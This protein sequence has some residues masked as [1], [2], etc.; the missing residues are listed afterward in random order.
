[1]RRARAVAY[2]TT[3]VVCFTAVVILLPRQLRLDY[4]R[5]VLRVV[6]ETGASL[7]GLFTGFLLFGRLRRRAKLNELILLYAIAVLVLSN[8]LALTELVV[9]GSTLHELV[10][11]VSQ[12]GRWVGGFLFASAAFISQ[13]Q[14]R[15]LS[16]RIAGTAA[17]GTAVLLAAATTAMLILHMSP[18]FSAARLDFPAPRGLHG[19]PVLLALELAAAVLYAMA[20]AGF[21][22]CR[23]E[24]ADEFFGW[25]AGAAAVASA[26]HV[27][28]FFSF[29]PSLA[30]YWAEAGDA[31]R[32]AFFTVLLAG[33]M[34]EIWSYWR[35]LSVLAVTEERRRIARNLHDG[36]AQE[37][38]Y[39]ARNLGSLHRE[40]G[41]VRVAQL[42]QAAERAQR[43]SRRAISTLA[44]PATQAVEVELARAVGEIADRF[45]VDLELDLAGDVFLPAARAD[46]LLRIACEA[47]ANAARHS[48]ATRVS[49]R[50]RRDG[51]HVRL[52]VSDTGRGFDTGAPGDGFGLISM[53]E[54]ARSAGGELR[55]YAAPGAGS[56]VEAVL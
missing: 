20:A 54:R 8:L 22:K 46:A 43:E 15:R 14:V 17:I 36:L 45:H 25:L 33:C 29:Y 2:G 27:Q 42:L 28:Y 4:Q 49:V 41:E 21:L 56:E 51:Q 11:G 37:L 31:L 12:G 16:L 6:L 38:A 10:V 52:R 39:L 53:R 9:T 40:T 7:V 5:A 1:M 55:V 3:A 35:T 47:V 19:Y 24:H 48:G 50:L 32:F 23:G 34:R 30:P 13:R 26:Q 44:A 18:E